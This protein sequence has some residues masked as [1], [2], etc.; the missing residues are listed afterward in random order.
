ME[1][2]EQPQTLKTNVK[3][4]KNFLEIDD[5]SKNY[6]LDINITGTDNNIVVGKGSSCRKLQ[7]EI[8]GNNNLVSIGENCSVVGKIVITGDNQKVMIGDKTTFGNATL[9]ARDGQDII[10]GE[11]CLFSTAIKVRT[12]DSHPII[13]VESGKAINDAETVIIGDHVWVGAEVVILK[14][15]E[16]PNDSIIGASSVV[17]KKFKQENTVIAGFPAQVIKE[18]TSW[19]R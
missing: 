8:K 14:G 12:S 7:I 15:A 18:G 19:E 4:K 5:R 16:I 11:D 6:N 1:L 13:E 3:G 9:L 2:R 17:T 10:I